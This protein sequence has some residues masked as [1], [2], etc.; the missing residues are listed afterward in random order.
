MQLDRLIDA[1]ENPSH[2]GR[3]EELETLKLALDPI[4]FHA[5]IAPH[6]PGFTGRRWIIDRY[7]TWLADEPQN[8]VLRIE[9]GPGPRKTAVASYLAHSTKTSVLAVH[10]CQWNKGDSRNPAPGANPG[11]P[12]GHPAARL[13]GA[14]AQVRRHPAPRNHARQGPRFAVERDHQRP[15]GRRRQR[16]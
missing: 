2:A 6:I 15:L 3:N 11:L 1:I 12:V 5:E 16:A 13:P 10:L 7:T 9:G 4:S 14:T 8:R